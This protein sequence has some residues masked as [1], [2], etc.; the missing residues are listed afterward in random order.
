MK[1]A[2][3]KVTSLKWHAKAYQLCACLDQKPAFFLQDQ[4]LQETHLETFL[5]KVAL[6]NGEAA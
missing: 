3:K 6:G 2:K 1:E 5:Q 4:L